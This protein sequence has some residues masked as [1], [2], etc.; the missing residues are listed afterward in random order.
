M[1]KTDSGRDKKGHFIKGHKWSPE[2]SEKIR[3][4]KKAN[5]RVYHSWITGLTKETDERVARMAATKRGKKTGP[6][7]QLRGIRFSIATEFKK[8]LVP[9]G[10]FDT[11][12][13]TGP[14]HPLWR[15]GVT[16][17][18]EKIRR[19]KQYKEWR[20]FVYQRDRFRCQICGKHCE[21]VDI[22]AHHINGFST[23]PSLRFT[24]ANGTTLCR[25]CHIKL[26]RDEGGVLCGKLQAQA[27]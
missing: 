13:K 24:V 18:H 2:I 27:I 20:D 14:D 1:N 21:R 22:V 7:P 16:S 4:T 5:P 17:E 10:G 23:Y 8:G 6:R 15:G 3:A 25:R 26:H 11:R 9:A 19:G 12:F